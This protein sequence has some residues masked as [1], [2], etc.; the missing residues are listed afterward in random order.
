V[1]GRIAN[2]N[3]WNCKG[4]N[5][6][7][8]QFESTWIPVSKHAGRL[9]VWWNI[10]TRFLAASRSKNL[11]WS[12]NCLTFWSLAV[13]LRTTRFN[14]KKV[15]VVPTLPLCVLY[16]SQNKQQLLPYKTLRDWFL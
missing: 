1:C 13:T 4:E 2:G 12:S 14:I 11:L 8:K 9:P 10:R 7:K 3:T 6:T 16:G 5:R 15:C